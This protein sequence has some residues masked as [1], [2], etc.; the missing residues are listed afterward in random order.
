MTR[1]KSSCFFAFNAFTSEV[2]PNNHLDAL[3]N[4]DWVIAMEEELNQFKRNEVWTLVENL[5][6]IPLLELNGFS[7]IRKMKMEIL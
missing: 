5:L 2:E 1:S 6:T 3:S 4:Q 7:R